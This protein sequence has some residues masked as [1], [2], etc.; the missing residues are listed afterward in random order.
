MLNVKLLIF[1]VLFSGLGVNAATNPQVYPQ[2]YKSWKSSIIVSHKNRIARLK[3]M[4]LQSERSSVSQSAREKTK[5]K[6]LK[7]FVKQAKDDL[8]LAKGL[9]FDHYVAVYLEKHKS[10]QEFMKN[11]AKKMSVDEITQLLLYLPGG[12][13]WMARPSPKK[14]SKMVDLKER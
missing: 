10:N 9:S 13:T 14:T 2:T 5:R 6:R 4:I 3:N 1:L 12:Q 8:K 7:A 11:L